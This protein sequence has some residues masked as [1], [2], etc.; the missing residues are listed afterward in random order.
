MSFFIV[1]R[2]CGS[3]VKYEAD[4]TR[5]GKSKMQVEFWGLFWADCIRSLSIFVI[6]LYYWFDVFF[7]K[8]RLTCVFKQYSIVVICG[9]RLK[10]TKALNTMSVASCVVHTMLLT[11]HHP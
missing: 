3:Y 8:F 11:H 5:L 6:N 9:R 10:Q 2:T 1:P 4:S 7:A